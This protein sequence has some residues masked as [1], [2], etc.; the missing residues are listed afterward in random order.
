[1]AD[2]VLPGDRA[3]FTAGVVDYAREVAADPALAGLLVDKLAARAA[4]EQRGPL[5]TYRVRELAQM[6]TRTSRCP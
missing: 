3:G 1:L 5:D 2:A 4:D 6:S